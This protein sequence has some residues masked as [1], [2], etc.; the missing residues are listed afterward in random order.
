[1]LQFL[2]NNFW[3]IAAVLITIMYLKILYSMINK[4]I[5]NKK[6]T[7]ISNKNGPKF[8][9]GQAYLSFMWPAPLYLVLRLMD[10]I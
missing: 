1:M 8:Y 4:A 3:H 7:S 10:L 9:L 2:Q 6:D 5:T